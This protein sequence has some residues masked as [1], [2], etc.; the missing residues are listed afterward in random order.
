M[1]NIHYEAPK[2]IFEACVEQGIKKIIQ[3]SALGIDKVDVPYAKSKLAIDNYLQTL[4]I[5]S[6]IVRPGLVYGKGAYGGSSLFRGLAGLP[7]ILPMPG[8]A[9]QLQQPIHTLEYGVYWVSRPS[10]L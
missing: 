6:T 4:D 7:F 2:A 3:I 1:W 10:S 9:E 5:D 8:R